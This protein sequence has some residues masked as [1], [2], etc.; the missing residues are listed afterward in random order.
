[1]GVTIRPFEDGD[2][3]AFAPIFL[4]QREEEDAG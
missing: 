2:L 3:S 4:R 1:M